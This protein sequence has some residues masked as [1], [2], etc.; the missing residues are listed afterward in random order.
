MQNIW[1]NDHREHVEDIF[2]LNY[3]FNLLKIEPTAT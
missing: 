3:Q 2:D 1:L